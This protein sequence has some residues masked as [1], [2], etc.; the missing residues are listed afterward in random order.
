MGKFLKKIEFTIF[1]IF[2]FAI[3]GI[4]IFSLTT[5][6]AISIDYGENACAIKSS[7]NF[8]SW[9][10]ITLFCIGGAIILFYYYMTKK[11]FKNFNSYLLF[12]LV[13]FAIISSIESFFIGPK[14]EIG[15]WLFGI[16]TVFA[17]GIFLIL[18]G[19]IT[20]KKSGEVK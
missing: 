5:G 11:E 8:F 17:V 9:L 12:A 20:R 14:K 10:S 2:F 7:E 15:F 4:G 1:L 13:F 19:W 3:L 18:I 6:C 16:I